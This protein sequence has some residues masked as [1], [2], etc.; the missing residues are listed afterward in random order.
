MNKEETQIISRII[1]RLDSLIYYISCQIYNQLES[2]IYNPLDSQLEELYDQLE[3]K[4]Q[5]K[6]PYK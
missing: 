1:P 3:D 2:Q 5:E 6:G 4:L